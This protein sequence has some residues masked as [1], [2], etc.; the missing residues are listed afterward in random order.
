MIQALLNPLISAIQQ[1]LSDPAIAAQIKRQADNAA[2]QLL[3]IDVNSPFIKPTWDRIYNQSVNEVK[4]FVGIAEED[5]DEAAGLI[6][7]TANNA[8]DSFAAALKKRIE[9]KKEEES[10]VQ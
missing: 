5:P 4:A 8:A 1:D 3:G 9:K 2:S 10:H 6:K 7:E